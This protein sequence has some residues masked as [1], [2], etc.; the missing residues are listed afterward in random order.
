MGQFT[1]RR[2]DPQEWAGLPSEP[3]ETNDPAIEDVAAVADAMTVG[4]DVPLSSISL[5]VPIPIVEESDAPAADGD[6]D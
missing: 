6:G 2:E 4:L 3:F 1:S 5:T